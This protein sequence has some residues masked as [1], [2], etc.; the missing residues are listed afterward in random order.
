MEKSFR[1]CIPIV[2][3]AKEQFLAIPFATDILMPRPMAKFLYRIECALQS[4]LN[5]HSFASQSYL[6][7]IAVFW[8]DRCIECKSRNGTDPNYYRFRASSNADF[9]GR[10][11]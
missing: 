1:I 10:R 11:C 4:E 7:H 3:R 6:I 5:R 9:N 2:L 8:E